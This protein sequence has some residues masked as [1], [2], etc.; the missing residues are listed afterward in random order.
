[1]YGD[2]AEKKELAFVGDGLF[3]V[4]AAQ[5]CC[6]TCE[7]VNSWASHPAEEKAQY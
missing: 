2:E 5:H 4:F 7:I 3:Q 6:M 1:L